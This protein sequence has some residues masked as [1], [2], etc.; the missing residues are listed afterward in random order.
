MRYIEGI[1]RKRKIQFPEYIDDYITE[2]NVVRVIDAFVMSLDM[3]ELGFKNA[4]PLETGRFGYNPRDLLK[5][6]IY[7]YLNGITSSR[8]LE[9]EAKRNIEAIWL[10][11]F[12]K[13]DDKTISDFRM[14]NKAILKNVFKQFVSLCK[15]WDLFGMEL[16]AVDG[17]K[18][19]ACNSKK[20]NFNDKKLARKIK[21]LDEKIKKYMDEIDK[22]DESEM[23]IRK[24]S[25]EEINKRITEL[26][27]R[28][29]TYEKYKNEISEKKITEISTTDPDARLMA[30]NNNGVNVCY[31]V[32]TVVDS[33]HCLIVD[34]D[35]I[36]NPTDHG[37]LSKMSKSAKDIFGVKTL[38][39]LADKGYYSTTDLKECECSDIETYVPK[40]DASN[41]TGE[42]EYYRDS[43]KYCKDENVYVCP[44][45]QKLYPGRL[46]TV[47]NN[48][49]RDY[50][51]Y[52]VCKNCQFKDKCTTSTKGRII[53]RNLEQELLDKVDERTKTNKEL[54]KKR[55]MIVEHPF[56]TIK[57]GI[58]ISHFLTKGLDSVRSEVSLAFLAYNMKRVINILG[59]KE[60]MNRLA[61]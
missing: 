4:T 29:I 51:N 17:S 7:G 12:L 26:K 32:Q 59:F 45:G 56:G 23:A 61:A 14:N 27:A 33:K 24:P 25:S 36:N 3:D 8:K 57:R 41:S 52:K 10:L 46:R 37:Q 34:C 54:Y 60:I 19:R 43:F 15:Q 31:N 11:R 22:N 9:A 53:A 50:K 1:N 5:L 55:Q 42:K 39:V 35:A 20:N 49:Y 21:Y 38:K 18:F 6:Y 47:G 44:V 13:P 2:D 30:V 28:K 48:K 40:Q 58:G 16:V